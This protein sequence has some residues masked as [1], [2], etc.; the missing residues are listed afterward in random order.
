M[1]FGEV[2]TAT[3]TH[4]RTCAHM[5]RHMRTC[6]LAQACCPLPGTQSWHL[7][8]ASTAAGEGD[9]ASLQ[10]ATL[11]HRWHSCVH[12]SPTSLRLPAALME[13]WDGMS[14]ARAPEAA[15]WKQPHSPPSSI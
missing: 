13:G 9:R 3:H 8:A 4:V 10:A 11:F 6:S 14:H 2:L 12:T 15:G 1:V 5:H 7:P